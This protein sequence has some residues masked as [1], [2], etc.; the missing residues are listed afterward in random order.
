M[1]EEEE[2]EVGEG[3]PEKEKEKLPLCLLEEQRQLWLEEN[4]GTTRGM[5]ATG[6]RKRLCYDFGGA[7]ESVFP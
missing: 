1:E 3:K 4:I 7:D 6:R 2:K 5:E